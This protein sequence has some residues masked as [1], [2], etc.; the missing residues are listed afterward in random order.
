MTQDPRARADSTVGV[1][2]GDQEPSASATSL[3]AEPLKLT[4]IAQTLAAHGGGTLSIDL[5]LDIVLNDVVEQARTSTGATGAAIAL[6][7]DGE[8]I[9]RATSGQNAP[10]MGVR[11]DANS[12]LAGACVSTGEIQQCQDTEIDSR[13]NPE[14]CRQLGVRSMLIAPLVDGQRLI[15]IIQVLSAWP[16]AFGKR[17]ISALQVIAGRIAESNREAE[18]GTIPA[19]NAELPA[20][21]LQIASAE[22][23][24]AQITDEPAGRD[25]DSPHLA[26]KAEPRRTFDI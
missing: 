20:E 18:I 12:G 16:N 17:E 8:L 7:R 15:G 13:V 2:L 9:C 19:A 25:E 24:P 10:D 14:T 6:F 26:T 23:P 22:T 11:V 3:F 5:A 4:Q 21:P 1:R